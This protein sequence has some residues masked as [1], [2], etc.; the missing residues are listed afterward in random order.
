MDQPLPASPVVRVVRKERPARLARLLGHAQRD[1]P[2]LAVHHLRR[3]R[4]ARRDRRL[5]RGGHVLRLVLQPADLHHP[6]HPLDVPRPRRGRRRR[7]SCRSC[8]SGSCTWQRRRGCPTASRSGSACRCSPPASW[9]RL[10]GFALIQLEGLPQLPTGTAQPHGRVL[11]A[12]R[13][14]GRGGVAVR[15]ATA[16][17]GRRSSGSTPRAGPPASGCSSAA[18]WRCTPAT[19]RSWFREGPKEGDAVLLPVRDP[20]RRRQVHPRRRADDGR[21]LHE[22]P[23]GHLQRPPP[24]GPQVQLVQ[25]PGVPVQRQRDARRWRWSGTAT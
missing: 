23:P 24:L 9:S 20:H 11:A 12:H 2:G 19:R 4:P 22:V 3:V 1:P 17:P 7:C 14:A 16:A 10:T 25:Q 5:P 15:R 13:A 8:C 6:V 18:W 21:V